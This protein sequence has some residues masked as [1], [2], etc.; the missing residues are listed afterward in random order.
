MPRKTP[1]PMAGEPGLLMTGSYVSWKD[2][3]ILRGALIDGRSPSSGSLVQ[4][5]I[6]E[7]GFATTIPPGLPLTARL[8]FITITLIY[9]ELCA[10]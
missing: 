7:R 2:E 8:G 10:H 3:S 9:A 4:L 5:W 1:S 6:A